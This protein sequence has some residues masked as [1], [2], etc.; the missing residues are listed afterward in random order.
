[1]KGVICKYV[2][3]DLKA[4]G[5]RWLIKTNLFQEDFFDGK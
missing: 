4:M 2:G 3:S 5:G 1:M